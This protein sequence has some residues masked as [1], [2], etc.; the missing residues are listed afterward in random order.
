[1]AVLNR[2]FLIFLLLVVLR[3]RCDTGGHGCECCFSATLLAIPLVSAALS[4]TQ[5]RDGLG[6][7]HFIGRVGACRGDRGG[8]GLLLLAQLLKEVLTFTH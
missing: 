7:G 1:M 2:L 8:L 6:R 4:M 3:M 5:V